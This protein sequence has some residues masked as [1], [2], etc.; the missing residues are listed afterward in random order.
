MR[1]Q[2]QIILALRPSS[3]QGYMYPLCLI[4]EMAGVRFRQPGKNSLD[5]KGQNS[6]MR[7]GAAKNKNQEKVS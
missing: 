7:S 3:S 4:L 2:M 6:T 5:S 1:L